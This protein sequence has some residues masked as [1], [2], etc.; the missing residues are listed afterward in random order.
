M[1]LFKVP[2]LNAVDELDEKIPI[3]VKSIDMHVI[4]LNKA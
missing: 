3:I 1:H 4:E 2:L